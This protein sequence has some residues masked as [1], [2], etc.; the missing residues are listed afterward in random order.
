MTAF[1]N[2]FVTIYHVEIYSFKSID[3]SL[4]ISIKNLSKDKFPLCNNVQIKSEGFF[5]RMENEGNLI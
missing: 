3:I 4:S 2:S 1:E 5:S